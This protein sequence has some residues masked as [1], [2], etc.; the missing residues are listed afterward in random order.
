M[1]KILRM[2]AKEK[3]ETSD[4]NRYLRRLQSKLDEIW[5]SLQKSHSKSKLPLCV[6]HQDLNSDNIFFRQR[7]EKKTDSE[8]DNQELII[9]P[10]N[11]KGWILD[12]V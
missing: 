4:V 9:P 12:P 6:I 11:T 7:L 5:N 2:H 10:Y 8:E 1:R 3:E